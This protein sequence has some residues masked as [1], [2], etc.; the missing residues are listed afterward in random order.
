MMSLKLLAQIKLPVTAT[1]NGKVN[2]AKT[3]LVNFQAILLFSP[4]LLNS[5]FI[6]IP[7]LKE[8]KRRLMTALMWLLLIIFFIYNIPLL[9]KS[10]HKNNFF[11]SPARTD[12]RAVR[13]LRKKGIF[14]P[15]SLAAI[16]T[17][18]RVDL[19]AVI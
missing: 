17:N 12:C 19:L 14:I 10:V 1:W 7:P 11:S 9:C 6:V 4:L 3:S 5:V 2:M 16:Y 8:H 15:C 18:L 13:H